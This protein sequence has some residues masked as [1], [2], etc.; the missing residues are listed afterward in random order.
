M[1][2]QDPNITAANIFW[3]VHKGWEGRTTAMSVGNA[4]RHLNQAKALTNKTLLINRI[5]RLLTDIINL[6]PEPKEITG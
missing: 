2:T 6:A 3:Q 5:N 4:I 1:Q